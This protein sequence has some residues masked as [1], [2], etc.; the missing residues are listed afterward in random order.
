M[1]DAQ[2]NL[3]KMKNELLI[4]LIILAVFL[5]CSNPSR[6]QLDS[7]LLTT[8]NHNFV[9]GVARYFKVN[10][11][12]D[13]KNCLIFSYM[14]VGKTGYYIGISGMWIGPH[15]WSTFSGKLPRLV[16]DLLV[17]PN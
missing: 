2:R 5:I 10:F 1:L 8:L 7:R 16:D 12:G 13:L 11:G 3:T 15:Y 14:H 4:K 17:V 9:K 6:A